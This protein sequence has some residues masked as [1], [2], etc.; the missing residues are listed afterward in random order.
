[1]RCKLENCK[2]WSQ[3]TYFIYY[4]V[5]QCVDMEVLK[6]ALCSSTLIKLKKKK[7]KKMDRCHV[8]KI[9]DSY[10]IPLHEKCKIE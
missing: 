6:S 7:E 1:M 3:Q 4:K 8:S 10:L 2:H 5:L 9:R